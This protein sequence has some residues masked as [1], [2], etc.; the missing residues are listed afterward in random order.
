MGRAGRGPGR[1]GVTTCSYSETSWS[2][3]AAGCPVPLRVWEECAFLLSKN[4]C[5]ARVTLP[6]ELTLKISVVWF[7]CG[8]FQHPCQYSCPLRKHLEVSLDSAEQALLK[9]LLR[10][11][12]PQF[13][14]LCMRVA[15]SCPTLCDVMDCSLPGSSVHGILQARVLESV[16]ISF[17]RG[18]SQLRNQTWV[19]C[20]AERFFTVKP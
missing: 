5:P 19:S 3:E 8:F 17:S 2:K 16:A 13:L 14:H 18:S 9:L 12:E 20:T 10:V 4:F 11:S 7:P 1:A 15:Q 6:C